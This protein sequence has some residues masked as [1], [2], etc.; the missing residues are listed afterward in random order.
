MARIAL[1]KKKRFDVFKR[2]GFVCQYCGA[3]PPGVILHVDHINPVAEGGGNGIDNL[4]T[5][6]EACNL[7]KAAALLS[8]IPKSLKDKANEIAEREEQIKGYNRILQAQVDRIEDECWAVAAAL[9][10]KKRIES[11]NRSRL[12]SIRTFLER[13]SVVEVLRAAE[14][15]TAKF[16]CELSDREFR[17]FCGVCWGIIRDQK[18]G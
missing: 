16:G 18:N 11:Y 5:A 6:C 1:S 10:C 9:S 3:T 13:L 2:D 17:Y 7:G 15:T 8:D 14:R 4:I 12:Q